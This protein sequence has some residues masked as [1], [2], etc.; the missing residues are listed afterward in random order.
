[1]IKIDRAIALP[2]PPEAP[3][4]GQR[5]R[6]PDDSPTASLRGFTSMLLGIETTVNHA[7]TI[8][9][10]LNERP[11]SS[12]FVLVERPG[13]M[14]NRM[15][16]GVEST[17]FMVGDDAWPSVSL[18]GLNLNRLECH[19]GMF[20]EIAFCQVGGVVLGQF[21][22]FSVNGEFH[23]E[24][25][26]QVSMGAGV[27]ALSFMD[28][29]HGSFA[30]F[31]NSAAPGGQV[32]A[33]DDF[34]ID[35]GF[36]QALTLDQCDKFRIG[37]E[38]TGSEPY[39]LRLGVELEGTAIRLNDSSGEIFGA[40]LE[41]PVPADSFGNEAS[42]IFTNGRPN[43]ALAGTN[44]QLRLD[45]VQTFIP[46]AAATPHSGV[47]LDASGAVACTVQYDPT[48]VANGLF[49]L[50]Q[51]SEFRPFEL[52]QTDVFDSAHNHYLS[53]KVSFTHKGMPWKHAF[54]S[55]FQRYSVTRFVPGQDFRVEKT[56][57]FS[58]LTV[59]QIAGVAQQE[60]LPATDGTSMHLTTGYSLVRLGFDTPSE[61]TE[62]VPVLLN[63][64]DQ[65]SVVLAT[66]DPAAP[67]IQIGVLVRI[68]IYQDNHPNSI[69]IRLGLVK[70]DIKDLPPIGE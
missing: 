6:F 8:T 58:G 44:R 66:S 52:S 5:V 4:A 10:L 17:A 19:G 3:Q 51:T 64:S 18:V 15:Q 12:D 7:I 40:S 32:T 34:Q 26:G 38:R 20:G 65:G 11:S 46:V 37:A 70:L 2:G 54:G 68:I 22:Q 25:G 30:E 53:P 59:Q 43:I 28:V 61:I 62:P 31:R 49:V 9:D 13:P 56:R 16:L 35:A 21:D 29:R 1:M 60:Y 67:Q 50:P 39:R 14:L 23:T 63:D 36:F 48:F 33:V 57:A 47:I 55:P 27:N 45:D 41:T 24:T 69:A 42:F